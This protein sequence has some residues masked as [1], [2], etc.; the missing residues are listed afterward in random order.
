MARELLSA[1]H[2][3]GGNADFE[4]HGWKMTIAFAVARFFVVHS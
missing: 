2:G 3:D 1:G 4:A